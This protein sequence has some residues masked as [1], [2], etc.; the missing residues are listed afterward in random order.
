MMAARE[1]RGIKNQYGNEKSAT[2]LAQSKKYETEGKL[3]INPDQI[4]LTTTGKLFADGISAELF[5]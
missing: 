5:F 1:L 4:Q 2:I 3:I